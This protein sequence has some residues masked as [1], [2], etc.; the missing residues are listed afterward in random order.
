MQS[1]T[2]VRRAIHTTVRFGNNPSWDSSSREGDISS[3]EWL[4]VEFRFLISLCSSI[5]PTAFSWHFS[6]SIRNPFNSLAVQATLMNGAELSPPTL[7]CSRPF[8]KGDE[9]DVLKTKHSS[10]I[11][12]QTKYLAINDIFIHN[13]CS[14]KLLSQ[15]FL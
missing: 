6:Y 3:F 8:T 9:N 11:K 7:R 14:S 13:F 15:Y 4:I 2:R 10:I 12:P 1:S 5:I